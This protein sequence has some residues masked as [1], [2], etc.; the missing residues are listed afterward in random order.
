M[1]L[2]RWA[3]RIRAWSAGGQ[4]ADARVISATAPQRR[5][6]RDVYCYFDND[7][8]AHAPYDAAALARKLGLPTTLQSRRPRRRSDESPRG[9]WASL[10]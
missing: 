5:T 10:R 1:A 9:Q 8:K 4:P 7:V 3:E 2:E 6:A